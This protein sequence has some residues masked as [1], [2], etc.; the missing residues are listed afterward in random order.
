LIIMDIYKSLKY[1]NALSKAEWHI[2]PRALALL[3][4]W[5]ELLGSI[6]NPTIIEVLLL[7]VF[8]YVAGIAIEKQSRRYKD[9]KKWTYYENT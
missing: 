1:Y 2:S 9:F 8:L 7:F 5:F 3:I 6:V 4:S